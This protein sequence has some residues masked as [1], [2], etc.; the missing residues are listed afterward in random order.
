MLW[1]SCTVSVARRTNSMLTLCMAVGRWT[2]FRFPILLLQL[3]L[4]NWTLQELSWVYRSLNVFQLGKLHRGRLLA[5]SELLKACRRTAFYQKII[6]IIIVFILFPMVT[7]LPIELAYML[8]RWPF[9]IVSKPKFYFLFLLYIFLPFPFL[10]FAVISKQLL[11][12]LNFLPNHFEFLLR[13]KP[14]LFLLFFLFLFLSLR[15]TSAATTPLTPWL[16]Y[17][18]F[19]SNSPHFFH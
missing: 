1:L 17:I 4:R 19:P 10:I 13:T 14:F 18:L 5:T 11:A 16:F 6:V 3:R 7:I 2:K 12:L 15:T 8:L 9:L